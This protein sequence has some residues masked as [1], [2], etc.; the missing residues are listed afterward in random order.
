MKLPDELDAQLRSSAFVFLSA[1]QRK[2]GGPVR[3]RDVA[4][5][6]FEGRHVPLLDRQ[7]G[8]RKP[9]LLDAAE[10]PNGL[11]GETRLRPY[12]DEPA[13]DGYPR[14][15][16]RGTVADHPYTSHSGVPSSEDCL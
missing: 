4:R 1:V 16:W 15:K 2:T 14:H 13:A 7:R 5:F 12:D 6:E 3:F 11:R 8:I 10:L 9:R